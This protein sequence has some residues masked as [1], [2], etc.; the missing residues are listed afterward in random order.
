MGP[1]GPCE[2]IIIFTIDQTPIIFD[3][4]APL[5]CP[6]TFDSS[7]SDSSDSDL[8][9]DS[10]TLSSGKLLKLIDNGK[11]NNYGEWKIQCQTEIC[12]LGLWKY[13][14]G[15]D[16]MPPVIPPLQEDTYMEGSDD[17]ENVKTFHVHGNAKSPFE[18]K[19]VACDI[20]QKR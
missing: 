10:K 6:E 1:Y 7:D 4:M 16:S 12:S 18:K 3:A 5:L 2:C 19:F 14:E 20:H 11:I 8:S 9:L 13:I 17:E 15:P